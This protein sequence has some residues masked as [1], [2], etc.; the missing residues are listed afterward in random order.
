VGSAWF[1][2][3]SFTIWHGNREYHRRMRSKADWVSRPVQRVFLLLGAS[4]LLTGPYAIGMLWLWYRIAGMPT[5]WSAIR[6]ATLLI[7][8][9]TMFIMHTYETVYLIRQRSRDQVAVE[10]LAR[11]KAQAELAVLKGQI[12]PHFMFNSLNTLAGLIE[13]DADRASEFTVSMAEVYRYILHGKDHELVPLEWEL[14]F[15]RNYYS[16][17][18][19]RFDDAIRL[20]L[21]EVN[22]TERYWV[23]PVSAQLLV[24]NAVKHNEFSERSPLEVHVELAREELVVR[25]DK[26]PPLK[27]PA[28]SKL[29]LQNLDERCRLVL[30]RPVQVVDN[31]VSFS[32]RL[33]VKRDGAAAQR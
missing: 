20:H 33:P 15:V 1:V 29:G 14:D 18:R 6:A 26:R 21:P 3:I 11:A 7:V 8:V 31:G 13:E 5:D 10:Q 27:R 19:L 4:L 12:D 17:L 24:E 30:G 16:L 23:L 9:C 2:L 25:N 28:T 32:V 22:D